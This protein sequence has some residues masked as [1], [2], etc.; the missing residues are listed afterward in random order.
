MGL[1]DATDA[2]DRHQFS[3]IVTPPSRGPPRNASLCPGGRA[4]GVNVRKDV[5]KMSKSPTW[6]SDWN[7]EDERFWNSTG[8][9]IARRN[10]IWSMV[11][12]HIGLSVGLIWS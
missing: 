4:G 10:L 3:R 8:K 12:E 1:A 7:P 6:S 9:T 11:A 5:S 2:V